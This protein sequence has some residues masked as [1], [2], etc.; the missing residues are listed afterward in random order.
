MITI[1]ESSQLQTFLDEYT[2]KEKEKDNKDI[3]EEEWEARDVLAFFIASLDTILLPFL[4]MML[5]L[6]LLST[7]F[8]FL[9]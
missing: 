3:V 1:S 9:Y 5:V 8:S 2:R 4:L 7:F 6:I